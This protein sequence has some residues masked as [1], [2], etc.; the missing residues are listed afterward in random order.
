[1]Q[2]V[3]QGQCLRGHIINKSR[4]TAAISK[5]PC[6]PWVIVAVTVQVS[7]LMLV[8][9]ID[10]VFVHHGYRTPPNAPTFSPDF[11]GSYQQSSMSALGHRRCDSAGFQ[12]D[13]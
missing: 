7:T 13:A 11:N 12:A 2:S 8:R 10:S 5:V 6:R 3:P 1:V 9:K 4:S